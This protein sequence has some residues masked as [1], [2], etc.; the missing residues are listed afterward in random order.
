MLLHRHRISRRTLLRSAALGGSGLA[1]AY[2][3]GCGDGSGEPAATSTVAAP[4]LAS[5]S[6][7]QPTAPSGSTL[8]WQQLSPAGGTGPDGDELPAP[9][10]DHSLIA[11]ASDSGQ[12]LLLFGGRDSAPLGD[13]WRYDIAQSQWTNKLV[14]NEG[15]PAR[16]GHNAVWDGPSGKIFVFGGQSGETFFN[17]L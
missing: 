6:T 17:D 15:P 5:A 9:R 3:V 1:G 11:A 12:S 7:T 10:R 4:P 8:R 13:L 2:L 16:H 14:A